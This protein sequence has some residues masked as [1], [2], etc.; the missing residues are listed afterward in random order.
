MKKITSIIT[1]C[2]T[3]SV[4]QAQVVQLSVEDCVKYAFENKS[5]LK[6]LK[7]EETLQK[8][9]NSDIA[10]ATKPQ[11]SFSG[12]GSGFL[13]VPKSRADAGA[14]GNLFG[15][16]PYIK[17]EA[18]DQAILQN[19]TQQLSSR[20]YNELQFA[21]PYNVSCTLSVTQILFEPSI[22]IA[23]EARAGLEEL[24]RIN[25][26]RSLVQ[27]RYD[28]TKAYYQ[29]L[30]AQKRLSLFDNNINLVNSFYDMTNKLFKEGFAEKIDADRLLVQRNNLTVEKNKVENLIALSYQL[31]KFQMG[32]P[33]TEGILLTDTLNVT[34]IKRDALGADLNFNNRIEIQQLQMA[35]KLQSLDIKRYQK[36]NLPTVVAFGNAGLGSSTKS[37][38]DLFTY[39]YFPQSL[40]GVQFSVPVYNGGARGLKV[41]QAEIGL[42]KL[43]NDMLTVQEAIS[44]EHANAKTQLTNSLIALDNQETNIGLAQRVYDVA[45]KKYKEGLGSSIEVL[46]AQSALKD[47]QSNYLNATFDV[48]NTYVDFQ[49][50]LG[51]LN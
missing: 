8:L 39:K 43:K 4:V 13:L 25:T 15:P 36:S 23:L 21:L 22:F 46:Q 6:S 14:F 9:R 11:V 33:L 38:G 10:T 51:E 50:A 5:T 31:L 17:A 26:A 18:I 28:I 48:V 30:I 42:Q 49:K 41:K 27:T 2:C 44:L 12:S 3:L 20:K 37:F 34:D 47:A 29:I 40:V 7:F 32:M 24:T 1:L 45:Q 16:A 19:Y 35:S